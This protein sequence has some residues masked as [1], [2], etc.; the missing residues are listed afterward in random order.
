MQLAHGGLVTSCAHWQ[1]HRF[2]NALHLRSRVY[3]A[4]EQNVRETLEVFV[5]FVL[6]CF[7]SVMLLDVLTWLLNGT[8]SGRSTDKNRTAG[9][10][11]S[12]GDSA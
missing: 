12:Y 11:R 6:T 4:A 1:R 7:T 8:P 5:L 9:E 2:T 10:D 3:S